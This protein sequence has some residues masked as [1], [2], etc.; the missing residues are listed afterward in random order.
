MAHDTSAARVAAN[1]GAR[2]SLTDYGIHLR[3]HRPGEHRTR[4]PQ[5]ARAKPRPGDTALA[6]RI[7]PDGSAVWFCHR[8]RWTGGIDP[9]GGPG[10]RRT[11]PS[12]RPS[13]PSSTRYPGLSA[14]AQRLWRDCRLITPGTPA[15]VYFSGRGCALPENDVRW[16]PQLRHPSG[17]TGPALVALVTDVL[18]VKP[19]NLH[20]TWLAPDGRGKAPVDRPRLVLKDH[21][22]GGGVVRL[23]EDAEVTL[24]LAI[25]EGLETALTAMRAF[26]SVWS[27]I[28]AGNIKAFPVLAGI[29]ALTIVEDRDPAGQEAARACADRWLAAR[30]DVWIWHA[31]AEGEDFNDIARKA[32]S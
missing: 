32:A 10:W 11:R 20:Q 6:V 30:V 26:Q 17:Y 23:V 25:A 9:D 5:C 12:E 22:L 29:E 18:T 31:T 8:C 24:G 28:D 3:A 4:C 27:C 2:P 21:R 19:I 13:P 16:Y 7:D 14:Y 1:G 15:A